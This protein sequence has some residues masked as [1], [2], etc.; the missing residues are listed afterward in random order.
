VLLLGNIIKRRPALLYEHTQRVKD[1]LGNLAALPPE[2]ALAVLLA[3]WPLCRS[4]RDLQDYVVLALRKV[5]LEEGVVPAAREGGGRGQLF[6]D[7][8]MCGSAW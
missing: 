1:C 8:H 7:C 5:G 6:V 2:G 4:R 3:L